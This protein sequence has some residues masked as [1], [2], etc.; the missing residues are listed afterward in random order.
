MVLGFMV[1]NSLGQKLCTEK[2]CAKTPMRWI[3]KCSCKNNN[4]NNNKNNNNNCNNHTNN[5]VIVIRHSNSHAGEFTRDE[6][7]K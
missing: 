4:I 1:G 2:K 5:N 6:S 3:Y 7:L